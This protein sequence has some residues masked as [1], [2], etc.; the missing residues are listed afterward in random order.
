MEEH[1]LVFAVAAL[2]LGLIVLVWS[3]DRFVDGAAASAKHLGM[4]PLLIGMVIVGFGTSAPEMVV[5][6]FAALDGNPGIA[7]GNAYGSNITNIALILGVTALLRPIT[8]ASSIVRL[9]LP[10]LLGVTA[11][12]GVLLYNGDL[13]RLDSIILIVVF[14]VLMGWMTWQNSRQKSDHLAAEVLSELAGDIMPLRKALFWSIAGLLL[15]IGSSRFIVWGAVEIA[16]VLGVDDLVI[17]LTV[18]ALGTSLPELAS[19]VVAVRKNEH[20]IAFGNIIGS[21][22][23]NTLMVVGLAGSI[24]PMELPADLLTRDFPIMTAVTGF[25]FVL[26]FGFHKA[27][28]LNRLEGALLLLVFFLYS[29]YL[30][31]TVV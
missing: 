16:T 24:S 5:S 21:N 23:F 12:T 10:L 30:V 11:L 27:K 18:I 20:D 13:T 19:S 22:L 3:A 28:R 9:E 1:I 2:V 8:V 15:L 14:A 29:V 4:S 6:L 7:L 31:M 26:V 25:L 17:G